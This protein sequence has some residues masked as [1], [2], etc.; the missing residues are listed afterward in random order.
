M[1]H[2][3][4][5]VQEFADGH[6]VVNSHENKDEDLQAVKEMEFKDL[7]HALTEKDSG[8]LQKGVSNHS[9]SFYGDREAGIR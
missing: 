8:L 6:V 4:R 2:D 7:D 5:V 3:G 1:T 9:R